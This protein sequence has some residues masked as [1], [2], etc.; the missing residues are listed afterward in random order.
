VQTRVL[1]LRLTAVP[2]AIVPIAPSAEPVPDV[3]VL[4]LDVVRGALL[5]V[6]GALLVVVGRGAAVVRDGWRGV[7]R[8]G[9]TVRG[10]ATGASIAGAGS[11][12]AGTSVND[13][14]APV[15]TFASSRSRLSVVSVASV[16]PL[17]SSPHAA[18]TVKVSE[19]AA[20]SRIY[21]NICLLPRLDCRQDRLG[22]YQRDRG[23][24]CAVSETP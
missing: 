19:S 9:V 3:E 24:S 18:A 14:C 12:E 13:G 21:F 1:E 10:A 4:P 11:A 23:K 16:S 6:R 8:V 22:C 2:E 20:N 17:L 15:S 5:V 7:V